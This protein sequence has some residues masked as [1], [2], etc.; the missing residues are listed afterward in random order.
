M[1]QFD[2]AYFKVM[3][4]EGGY[5]KDKDDPGGETYKGI[6]R[7]FNP[8]WVGWQVVDSYK[9]RA[10]FPGCLNNDLN[11]QSLVRY[12]YK[13]K[14]WDPYLG[15]QLDGSIAEEMFDQAVNLGL[16]KAL[17]NLQKSL[18]ILNRNQ[19]DYPD[20]KVDGSFGDTTLK[21]Y[22]IAVRLKGTRL[23]FNVLNFYQGAHYLKLMETNS[24]REKYIGWFNR[25]EIKRN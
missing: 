23:L 7:V 20:I 3:A 9:G 25:I 8:A 2:K 19:K 11:L 22:Q 1:N 21:T 5:I 12:L 13:K 16:G 10:D 17:E 18:N 15:D 4:V 24:V 14:Y 6:S